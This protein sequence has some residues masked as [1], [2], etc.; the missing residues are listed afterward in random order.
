MGTFA[1]GGYRK[2]LDLL[3]LIAEKK[4][5]SIHCYSA[6]LKNQVI[7]DRLIIHSPI[8]NDLLCNE[9]NKYEIFLFPSR[10]ETMQL[11]PLEAMA[12]GCPVIISD[13]GLGMELK[14]IIPEFV[15]DSNCPDVIQEYS[16]RID[17]IRN[18]F[19]F[20]SQKAE[21]YVKEYHSF[22]KFKNEWTNVINN[23]CKGE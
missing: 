14:K 7:S 18:D 19:D 16:K 1:D 9:Y 3:E 11:S 22:Q 6:V 4:N 10:Y 23:V 21:E 5:I 2:G 15:I 8:S 13:V 12:C 20:Y 17:V